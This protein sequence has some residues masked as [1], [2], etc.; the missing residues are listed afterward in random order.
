MDYWEFIQDKPDRVAGHRVEVFVIPI[1][2]PTSTPPL[3]DRVRA[4]EEVM[5]LGD[6]MVVEVTVGSVLGV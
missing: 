3:M 1:Y 6:Q 4:G 2:S 5:K